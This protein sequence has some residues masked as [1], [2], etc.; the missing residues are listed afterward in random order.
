MRWMVGWLLVCAATAADDAGTI[1]IEGEAF[2]RGMDAPHGWYGGAVVADQLSGGA[3]ASAFGA[4]EST[5]LGYDLR[6]AEG[7]EYALWLRANPVKAALSWR[8]DDGEW[9]R[10]DFATAVDRV[11]IAEDGKPDLRYLAWVRAGDIDL[12]AGRHR[13][14]VRFHSEL[15]HH[16][17][18]DCFVVTRGPFVPNGKTRPGVALT[19]ADPGWFA[20]D[21]PV[22]RFGD[23]ALLDLRHLNEAR[24][25]ASGRLRRDRDRF[26]LG[27]GTQVR[28][29]AAN[30]GPARDRAAQEYLARRL[31]KAGFNCARMHGLLADRSA[32]DPTALDRAK[33]DRVFYAVKTY[34]DAGIYTHLSTWF[35]LW[36]RVREGDRTIGRIGERPTALLFIDPA[37]RRLWKAWAKELLTT[38]NPH[39]GT[40]LAED[41][42]VAFFELQNEDNLFFYT[43][44]RKNVGDRAWRAF[45]RAFAAWLIERHGSLAKARA[46]WGGADHDADDSGARRMGLYGAWHHTRDGLRKAGGAAK[47]KRLADQVR[48]L[49]GLQRSVYRELADFVRDEC[50]FEGMIVCGNWKAADD[51]TM[52]GVDRW[53]TTVGDAIDKHGYFGG[54]HEGEASGYS[55]RKGHRFA[56]RSALEDPAGTPLGYARIA[57][58]PHIVSEIAWPEPN[59]LD[60]DAPL[61]IASYGALQGVD[62]YFLFATHSGAWSTGPTEKWPLISP[63]HY[64]QSIAAA[65]Q[66]RRGD[67]AEA[68]PAV[69]QVIDASAMF[70][71]ASGGIVEGANDDFRVADRAAI[72]APERTDAFDPL[73]YFVGP[74]ERV[75][76][77]LDAAPRRAR[78]RRG[79]LEEFID[80]DAGTVRSRTGELDLDWKRGVLRVDTARSQAASGFLADAGA[81]ELRDVTI[82][83]GNRYATIQAISLDGEPLAD[84]RRILIQ[85]FT[86]ERL[87]GFRE[88]D[89]VI[90]DFGRAPWNVAEVDASVE[91]PD[92]DWRAVACDP[93]GYERDVVPVRDD[94]IRLPADALYTVLTR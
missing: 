44:A 54:P 89:G 17:S 13:L 37:M 9:N 59:R 2:V 50:G 58:Y 31:A 56:D 75:H 68:E 47:R 67:V 25:G 81:V 27:D 5:E 87:Y 21:A 35:P 76:P 8:L 6:V 20:V 86:R 4:G 62:G 57:G 26:V 16:G 12:R 71:F 84:S 79:D 24:A 60:A 80:R 78:P 34:R 61:A 82:R 90:E 69:V 1:W 15:E 83:C 53:T 10:V 73:T 28:L 65:L 18:L 85:A 92:G 64:G 70:D 32:K 91:L 19:D 3:F 29:W 51:A 36:M 30:A 93:H 66:Y 23:D 55:V 14:A 63:S 7:G 46:A 40:T 94:R 88:R 72:A 52:L 38:R 77:D 74:V 11:N 48:F 22:D 42:S 39:T 41:P 45:E 33:L 49:A 43:F